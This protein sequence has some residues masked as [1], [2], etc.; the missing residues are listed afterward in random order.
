MGILYKN[1]I[2]SIVFCFFVLLLR[3]VL[4][5][6][7]LGKEVLVSSADIIS[8]AIG[9]LLYGSICT[10]VYR[11]TFDKKPNA[12]FFLNIDARHFFV[13]LYRVSVFDVWARVRHCT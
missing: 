10:W 8:S 13:S 6:V 9:A 12:V 3:L 7:F 2:F 11:S 1:V 5:P 4:F